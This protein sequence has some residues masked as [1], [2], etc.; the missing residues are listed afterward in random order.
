MAELHVGTG[1][2]YTDIQSGISAMNGGDTLIIHE[3]T[4]YPTWTESGIFTCCFYDIPKGADADNRTVIKGADGEAMP[5]I[6]GQQHTWIT[7]TTGSSTYT[8]FRVD[9]ASLYGDNVEISGLHLKN[10]GK[11]CIHVAWD[12]PNTWIHHNH[13]EVNMTGASPVAR[14]NAGGVMVYNGCENTIIEYNTGEFNNVGYCGAI[15]RGGTI[16]SGNGTYIGHNEFHCVSDGADGRDSKGIWVKWEGVTGVVDTVEYNLIHMECDRANSDRGIYIHSPDVLVQHNVVYGEMRHNIQVDHDPGGTSEFGCD[17]CVVRN[18]SFYGGVVS[19]LYYYR[20]G[21]TGNTGY[22]KE[23]T[24]QDTVWTD[25]IFHSF[26]TAEYMVFSIWDLYGGSPPPE[27]DPRW[28]SDYNCYYGANGLSTP[29]NCLYSSYTLSDWQATDFPGAGYQDEHSINEDPLFVNP[30]GGNLTLSAGSPCIA[31]GSG[32]TNMGAD[33]ELVGISGVGINSTNDLHVGTGQTYA[34]I[35]GA[36]AASVN[37]DIIYVHEGTYYENS[38]QPVNGTIITKASGETCP[39]IDAQQQGLDSRI[40]IFHF[41]DCSDITVSY[42]DC[43]GGGGH[44]SGGIRIGIESPVGT[45]ATIVENITIDHC[46]VSDTNTNSSAGTDNNPAHIRINYE[47]EVSGVTISNCELTGEDASGVKMNVRS[48]SADTFPANNITITRNYI[49]DVLA[50]IAP[51]WGDLTD[52]NIEF[53]HNWI[54]NFTEL[55]IFLDHSY[56]LVENNV[57]VSGGPL[58][59]IR[60]GENDG[61]IHNTI[62]NNTIYNCTGGIRI[63]DRAE[64]QDHSLNSGNT[65]KNNIIS[66]TYGADTAGIA[67]C[68]W[69]SGAT[70]D[71]HL[72]VIK[73]NLCYHS[74]QTELWIEYTGSAY[75]LPEWTA[76]TISTGSAVASQDTGSLQSDPLFANA[77]SCDLRLNKSSPAIAAGDDNENMG[78]DMDNVGIDRTT[79]YPPAE[80]SPVTLVHMSGATPITYGLNL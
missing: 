3:G 4:Y 7:G 35:S 2:T 13:F 5:I 36:I 42:M 72:T 28:T 8:M 52:R 53:T 17:R 33:L 64:N 61:G 6:D 44:E 37:G 65:I 20:P 67:L 1:Q 79:P 15:V 45:G 18:N 71:Q 40:G 11:V 66:Q 24:S 56:V 14:D 78:A 74:G 57:F 41:T 16:S 76:H 10:P 38:L 75:D 55:G 46:K 51:K 27:D 60:V 30:T 49:H 34:T 80:S 21:F 39:I 63:D 68:R 19:C 48:T 9:H 77:H 29:M 25:N 73:N 23:F 31:A 22:T 43:R 32:G 58:A 70:I 12:T 62:K 69:G 50:G 54:E 59:T 47:E 26:E